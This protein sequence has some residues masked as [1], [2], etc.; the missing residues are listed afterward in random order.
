MIGFNSLLSTSNA[1][2]IGLEEN[3]ARMK[4]NY[5]GNR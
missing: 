2:Q 1:M 4:H 5:D 3:C